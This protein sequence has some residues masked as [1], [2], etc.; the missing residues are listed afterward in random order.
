MGMV[1]GHWTLK[2]K[3]TLAGR[4]RVSMWESSMAMGPLKRKKALAG[5]VRVSN[6]PHAGA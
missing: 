3:Q 2:K 4:V 6:T 1:D 5:R